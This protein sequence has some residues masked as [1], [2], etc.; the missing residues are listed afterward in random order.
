[1]LKDYTENTNK[2][3]GYA[4]KNSL[5]QKFAVLQSIGM[6]GNQLVRMLILEGVRYVAAWHRLQKKSIVERLRENE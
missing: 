2:I 4:S 5:K 3:M 1:M 6:T